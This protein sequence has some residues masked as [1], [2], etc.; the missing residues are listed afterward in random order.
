NVIAPNFSRPIAILTAA[1]GVVV[2]TYYV[3]FFQD[4]AAQEAQL[5]NMA[6]AG[7][8]VMAGLGLLLFL[9]VFLPR[10][11]VDARYTIRRV[12]GN[13]ENVLLFALI[14]M[15]VIVGI[16]SPRFVAERNMSDIIM[17]TSYIAIAAIGMSMVIITG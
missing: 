14:A 17:T 15:V 16:A 5:L 11:K 2:L 10:Q 1:C 6:G 9:Q 13:Q 7:F 4:T 8:W 3:I 12:L